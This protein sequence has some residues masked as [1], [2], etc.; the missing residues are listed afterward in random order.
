[1]LLYGKSIFLVLSQLSQAQ[2]EM[3][4]LSRPLWD[5]YGLCQVASILLGINY[6]SFY[7]KI[8]NKKGISYTLL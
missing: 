7:Q 2:K 3:L 1:M 8:K 4:G 6:T 5:D